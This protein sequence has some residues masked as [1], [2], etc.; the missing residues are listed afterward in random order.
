MDK[1]WIAP[2]KLILIGEYAVLYGAV[3]LVTAVNRYCR[4]RIKTATGTYSL[5]HAD[6]TNKSR[7][8]FK[9]DEKE[10]F[11]SDH[12][13]TDHTK[14]AVHAINSSASFLIREKLKFVPCEISADT[15][16]FYFSAGGEKL[17]FGSSAA[18][19]VALVNAVLEFNGYKATHAE[20]FTLAGQIHYTAQGKR[21]SGIDIA[22]STF[23]GTCLYTLSDDQG[24]V[25]QIKPDR[26]IQIVSIWSGVPVSTTAMIS[27]L[28]AFEQDNPT[29]F[30]LL[31]AELKNISIQAC[32]HY[33]LK[34]SI[35]FLDSIKQ[36]FDQLKQ[37]GEQA[38]ID[39]ISQAHL[40]IAEITASYGAA[41]KPSGA[42]GGD[43]GTDFLYR[44]KKRRAVS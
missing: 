15:S 20:I 2:G 35:L 26:S 22:A 7:F 38:Q 13:T 34:K 32:E 3:S 24:S 33:R 6:N 30:H 23:G 12:T 5:F 40:D 39:I 8:E 25:T 9:V 36:Y 4:I 31:M 41:Y 11:I 29:T 44:C 14:F 37:I 17:G 43:V 19:T 10:G 42:G 16:D 21:G 27:G 1:T 28:S 18:L